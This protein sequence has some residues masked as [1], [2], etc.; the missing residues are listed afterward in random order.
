MNNDFLLLF[1]VEIEFLTSFS[2]GKF[3]SIFNVFI[4][5]GTLKLIFLTKTTRWDDDD[6][7]V[8]IELMCKR[9]QNDWLIDDHFSCSQL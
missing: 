8:V 7:A 1:D 5:G 2:C 9:K 4:V 6:V 3:S